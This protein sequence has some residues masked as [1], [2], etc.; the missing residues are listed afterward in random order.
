[1]RLPVKTSLFSFCTDLLADFFLD[2]FER[3]KEELLNVASLIKN[4]LA[5]GLDFAKLRIFLSHYLSEVDNL[6][7]L[8]TDNLFVLIPYK[9]FLLLKVFNDLSK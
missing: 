9:F 1:M 3:F 8:V 5:K 7:L 4:D 6:L 2:L